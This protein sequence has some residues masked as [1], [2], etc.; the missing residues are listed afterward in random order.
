M[1]NIFKSTLGIFIVMILLLACKK[2]SSH[3]I[4]IKN[5]YHEALNDVK[6][7]STNYGKIDIGGITDYKPVSEGNYTI[8]CSDDKGALLKSGTGRI[9]GSG[10]HKW[11]LTIEFNGT[12]TLVEDK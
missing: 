4:R 12:T 8:T 1:K 10:T 2:D 5:T 7:N 6:I 9:I 11:T 3:S